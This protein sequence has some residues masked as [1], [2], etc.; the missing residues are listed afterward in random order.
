MKADS[1]IFRHNHNNDSNESQHDSFS[2]R[3]DTLR[4]KESAQPPV[5]PLT[6]GAFHV[7]GF[8]ETDQSED[9]CME[10][11]SL[12]VAS[13]TSVPFGIE[14]VIDG[15][16]V[17]SPNF[18]IMEILLATII[19]I[20]ITYLG[21]FLRP[22]QN[23][24]LEQRLK[25]LFIN[26][27]GDEAI[28]DPSTPQHFVWKKM[29]FIGTLEDAP[30][31]N[32]DLPRIIQRYCLLVTIF[33][34]S[35]D[36]LNDYGD[37]LDMERPLPSE[38]KTNTCD[39]NGKVSIL[40]MQNEWFSFRGS[41]II[42]KEISNL[43]GLT[44]IIL[45]NNALRGTIPTEIGRLKK[46]HTL[47]LSKNA[48]TGFVPSELGALPNLEWVNLSEN[49]LS[50]TIPTEMGNLTK[51]AYVDLSQN[52]LTGQIPSELQSLDELK[53]LSFQNNDLSGSV[54]FLCVHNFT[55]QEFSREVSVGRS[56]FV[57]WSYNYSGI[58]GL[59]FDCGDQPRSISCNC[60]ICE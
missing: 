55:N 49:K 48:L 17:N 10:E 14:L 54:D 43:T 29:S 23:E 44:H 59:H 1:P 24:I 6:P 30:F 53:G 7:E 2:D 60:C 25:S 46:L 11:E 42:A 33:S 38:C 12:Q 13:V 47:D 19:I 39:E 5:S 3:A 8:N 31:D 18:Y 26:I 41:G 28:N 56:I 21:I 34:F 36:F 35:N 15:A 51:L 16:I 32:K 4:P 40:V 52:N 45:R 9:E 58:S 50:D 27:S 20:S 37:Q 22:T 57:E